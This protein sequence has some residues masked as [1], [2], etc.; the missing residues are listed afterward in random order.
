VAVQ[1][2]PYTQ[3]ILRTVSWTIPY[4]AA[5][6][7]QVEQIW[8]SEMKIRPLYNGLVYCVSSHSEAY[9]E[10]SFVPYKFL[11]AQMK[12]GQIA[13]ML[14]LR[15]L[16]V[17]GMIIHDQET[18]VG[19]RS[20]IVSQHKH[21][22][23][24][25]PS[26]SVEK[27]LT[28]SRQI[29]RE[30]HEEAGIGQEDIIS[31]KLLGLFYTPYSRNFDLGYIIHVKKKCHVDVSKEYARIEWMDV[32]ALKRLLYSKQRIVPLSRE[33]L[34]RFINSSHMRKLDFGHLI[35]LFD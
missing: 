6:L 13:S 17:S 19:R 31:L 8:A 2:F 12:D 22:V 4:E 15:P 1:F 27:G 3:D 23:E 33:L 14:Q 10:G 34:R 35:Q 16:G 24:C 7:K 29:V 20:A 21:Y 25:L 11:L 32:S 5:L 9:I 18:L 26:G 28:P 30:L